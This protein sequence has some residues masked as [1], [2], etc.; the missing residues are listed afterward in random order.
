V[1][2]AGGFSG[3]QA[4]T[5]ALSEEV[6]ARRVRVTDVFDLKKEYARRVDPQVYKYFSSFAL[7]AL[8][9]GFTFDITQTNDAQDD[10]N[11]LDPF[12]R[13]VFKLNA[14]AGNKYD[15]QSTRK[16]DV[17]ETFLEV[18]EL[19]EDECRRYPGGTK[20]YVYPITGDIGEKHREIPSP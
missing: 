3:K 16:F 9:F 11:F 15:R 4:Y 5:N 18:Y 13:G 8:A 12:S 2:G 20:N 19:L 7:S 6:R 1:G 17:G 10:S 14:K